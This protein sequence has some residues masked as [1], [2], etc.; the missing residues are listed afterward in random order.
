M[1]SYKIDEIVE[2]AEM[3]ADHY[4]L[5]FGD[6]RSVTKAYPIGQ[7]VYPEIEH[8]M[9]EITI[10][11][12][13][14]SVSLEKSLPDYVVMVTY[15]QHETSVYRRINYGFRDNSTDTQHL[16]NTRICDL[17][18]EKA[19]ENCESFDTTPLKSLEA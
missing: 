11:F 6:F 8:P 17:I 9:K 19:G 10:S 13:D 4:G 12:D 1:P 5:I 3:L 7:E 14:E 16:D 2:I 18:L 15:D